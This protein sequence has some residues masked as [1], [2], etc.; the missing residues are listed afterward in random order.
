[1]RFTIGMKLL[2]GFASVLMLMSVIGIFSIVK[3][4]EFSQ[5]LEE[6]YSKQLM[7]ISLVKE[8]NLNLVYRGRAEKNLIL[9]DEPSEIETHARAV[10]RYA[11]AFVAGMEEFKPLILTE[12][13]RESFRRY[14][15][16]WREFLPI[17]ERIVAHARRNEDAQAIEWAAKGRKLVDETDALMT[18]FVRLREDSA[19]EVDASSTATYEQV[20]V[21]TIGLL[22][23]ALALGFGIA[24]A[25]SR[26]ACRSS[27]GLPR[28]W[29]RA[30]WT[31]RSRWR[32]ATSWGT[33]PRASSG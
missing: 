23:V 13:G 27:H 9:A 33:W 15:E 19:R 2:A 26:R 5:M 16:A 22:L 1:M 10:T 24:V 18:K 20:R 4:G 7:G 3:L 17:Q 12:S 8:A 25:R 30:T 31:S 14:Q 29:P 32:A 11:D 21:L 6:M 28:A